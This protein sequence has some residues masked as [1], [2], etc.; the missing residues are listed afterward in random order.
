MPEFDEL[1]D[2]FIFHCTVERRLSSNTVLAYKSDLKDFKLFHS[3]AVDTDF[4]SQD[5]IKKYLEHMTTERELSATT[6]KRRI[7]SLKR[8]ASFCHE[9]YG[10]PSPF[11]NWQ[12]IIRQP[13]RLPRALSAQEVRSLL[14]STA[15]ASTQTPSTS[16][17][18]IVLCATGLRISELCNLKL[19]DI[20]KNGSTIHV[21]G[22][23]ARDRI[24]YIGDKTLRQILA[25]QKTSSLKNDSRPLFCHQ[26]GKPLTPQ[27]V[28]YRIH[29]LQEQSG[30]RKRVT[31][32]M[33]RHTAATLLIESGTDIRFVQKLL[34]HA[35]ISTTEI[36][37][38]VNDVALQRAIKKANTLERLKIM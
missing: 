11:Q 15:S 26:D 5:A 24:V 12:P 8:F 17:I 27:T 31:P 23:G 28:R 37:T 30:L 9:T 19:K 32:H 6:V 33:F 7:A 35:S 2:T 13:K 21:S 10:L 4:L 29:R 3:S 34:G 16:L 20:S 36:Y 1:R 22:K 14:K 38:Q 18:I 25:K